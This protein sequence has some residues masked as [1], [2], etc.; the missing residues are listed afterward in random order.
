[1]H[2]LFAR[3]A[4]KKLYE[5]FGGSTYPLP[6][7]NF[8]I[9]LD[10]VPTMLEKMQ[11]TPWPIYKIKLGTPHDIEIVRA[12][13]KHTDAI[14]RVDANGAWTADQT[15]ERASELKS[16]GVEWIEQPL[17][18]NDQEGM[19]KVFRHSAL[20][21]FADESCC[22]ESDV[23]RCRGPVSR[24]Q[25]QT[26]EMRRPHPPHLRMIRKARTLDMQVMVGCMTES[27]VGI[28]AIAQLLP[29]IDYVDMD[30]ALLLEN[31]PATGV[32]IDAGKIH[33]SGEPGTG[34]RLRRTGEGLNG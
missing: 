28:S 14:F 22:I 17:P 13:R 25:H 12:L 26:D 21:V 11:Q 2:D 33:F 6:L 27:S 31:D 8:T 23:E 32:T 29:L 24:H 19:K 9:G 10:D 3:M 16:L 15:V 18:A 34:A 5:V 30:G 4:G 7:T 1:M 20:P